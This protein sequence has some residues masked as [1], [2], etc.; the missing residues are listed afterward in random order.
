MAALIEVIVNLLTAAP[1]VLVILVVCAII[2]LGAFAIG[3]AFAVHSIAKYLTQII[4][5]VLTFTQEMKLMNKDIEVYKE[6][7]INEAKPRQEKSPDDDGIKH[8]LKILP[9]YNSN[10]PSGKRGEAKSTSS[11]KT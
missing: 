6:I 9:L 4:Q 1:W 11:A 8:L 7:K 10:S 2:L 5:L 3:I